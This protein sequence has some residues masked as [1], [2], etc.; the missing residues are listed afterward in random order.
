ML[1][2]RPFH[3]TKGGGAFNEANLISRFLS[4]VSWRRVTVPATLTVGTMTWINDPRIKVDHMTGSNQWDLIIEGIGGA[5]AGL[6]E[7][8]VSTRKKI[9]RHEVTLDISGK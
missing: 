4:Q 5:D 8:Q 7:C 6:Y 3:K 2:C 9:L 1:T